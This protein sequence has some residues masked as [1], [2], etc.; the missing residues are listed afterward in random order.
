MLLVCTVLYYYHSAPNGLTT[1]ILLTALPIALYF[2]DLK[3]NAVAL[4]TQIEGVDSL[5]IFNLLMFVFLGR[6]QKS[7]VLVQISLLMELLSILLVCLVLFLSMYFELDLNASILLC[8]CLPF[9][10]ALVLNNT[11][12]ILYFIRAQ[13]EGENNK[14]NI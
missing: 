14:G 5:G 10:I 8:F 4:D 13:E 1:L 2:F 7:I 11:R 12:H 6:A 3:K 9:V